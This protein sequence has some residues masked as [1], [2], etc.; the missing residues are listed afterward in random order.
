M[1]LK[2]DEQQQQRPQ[3]QQ[4]LGKEI[5]ALTITDQREACTGKSCL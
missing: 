5:T 4:Q 2:T 1:L 3:Q